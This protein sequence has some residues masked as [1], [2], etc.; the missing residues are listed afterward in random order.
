MKKLFLALLAGMMMLGTMAQSGTFTVKGTFEEM[1]DSVHFY[2]P[3]LRVGKCKPVTGQM[4]EVSFDL[5]DAETLRVSEY[6][7]G[8]DAEDAEGFTVPAIPGSIWLRIRA[9]VSRQSDAALDAPS[10]CEEQSVPP[11]YQ[12]PWHSL[13]R[14]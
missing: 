10:F 3:Q 4:L 11:R 13:K 1:G 14:K 12:H 6:R 2:F 5:V 8:A 9:R 7:N